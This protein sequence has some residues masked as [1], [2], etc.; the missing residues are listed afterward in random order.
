MVRWF[1]MA[2]REVVSFWRC[3]GS[4]S[5]SRFVLNCYFNVKWF[6]IKI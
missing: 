2:R 4:R 6:F 1:F 3:I 5:R